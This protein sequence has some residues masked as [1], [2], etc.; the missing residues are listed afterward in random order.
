MYV[1]FDILLWFGAKCISCI[2]PGQGGQYILDPFPFISS[3]G[4]SEARWLPLTGPHRS[5]R[6]SLMDQAQRSIW[7]T[8]LFPTLPDASGKLPKAV[9]G[10]WG[11]HEGR[12][13]PC[14]LKCP[15]TSG[16]QKYLP[17][18]PTSTAPQWI[19]LMLPW[20]PQN[21]GPSSHRV[22]GMGGLSSVLCWVL[23]KII[24][25]EWAAYGCP[26]VLTTYFVGIVLCF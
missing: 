19:C 3:F 13:P 5:I 24:A 25:L 20:S 9:A 21:Q 23:W 6:K 14:S 8:I 4:T 2:G 11:R 1:W 15:P 26:D 16:S 22:A 7:S 10:G 12:H 18:I 17:L